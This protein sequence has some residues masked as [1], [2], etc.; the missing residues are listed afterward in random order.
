MRRWNLILRVF[1]SEYLNLRPE[2]LQSRERSSVSR[3]DS[4][5]VSTLAIVVS[6][7][8]LSASRYR[9]WIKIY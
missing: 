2:D 3:S 4:E 8:Q 6:L 7:I 1:M 5:L 9:D